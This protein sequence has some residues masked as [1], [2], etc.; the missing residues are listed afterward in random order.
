LGICA[1]AESLYAHGVEIT[2]AW[3]RRLR[4]RENDA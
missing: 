1:L 2:T 3:G 4:G